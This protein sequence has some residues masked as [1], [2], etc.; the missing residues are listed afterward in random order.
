VKMVKTKA[1]TPENTAIIAILCRRFSMKYSAT[2]AVN[3]KMADS[4]TTSARAIRRRIPN[5]VRQMYMLSNPTIGSFYSLVSMREFYMDIRLTRKIF[6]KTTGRR[7]TKLS[8]S[9]RAN[10]SLGD[11]FDREIR[12]GSSNSSYARRSHPSRKPLP[13]SSCCNQYLKDLESKTS[14][15][16]SF[17]TRACWS[18]QSSVDV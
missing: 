18:K 3:G 4:T 9:H 2:M 8:S 17:E 14:A 1:N 7:G 11:L 5:L 6:L 15:R 10:L 13:P 16:S 12:S